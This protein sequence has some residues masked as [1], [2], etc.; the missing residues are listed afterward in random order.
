MKRINVT[1]VKEKDSDGSPVTG[2]VGWFDADKAEYFHESLEWD[3]Q[4]N[5][6]QATGSQF[7]HEM[8]IRTV[9]GRWVLNSYSQWQGSPDVYTFI[10]ADKAREWLIAQNHDKEVKRFFGELEEE[11]GPGQ[12]EIGAYVNVP[13][14]E[15][16]RAKLDAWRGETSRNEAIREAIRR[17]VEAEA[18][19][20]VGAK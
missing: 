16:L 10:T 19:A 6:S 20:K 17:L 3:G 11:R 13:L 7:D 18:P 1:G 8:L 9:Q 4:N 12:P 14:G 15:D 2:V 5:I